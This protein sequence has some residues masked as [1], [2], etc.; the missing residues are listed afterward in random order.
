MNAKK[1]DPPT[2]CLV[3]IF[4]VDSKE[5]EL[6]RSHAPCGLFACTLRAP[7]ADPCEPLAQV[8]KKACCLETNVDT[9]MC[10]VAEMYLAA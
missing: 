8:A 5:L 6:E 3:S 4:K 10:D 2:F 1:S 7:R 9:Q